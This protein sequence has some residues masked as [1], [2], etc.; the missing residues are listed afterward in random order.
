[1]CVYVYNILFCFLLAPP[2][3][4]Q[5]GD[6]IGG[7]EKRQGNMSPNDCI[8]HCAA[9]RKKFPT[10]NGVTVD[11]NGGNKCYCEYKMKS[12]NTARQWKTCKLE[13]RKLRLFVTYLS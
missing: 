9:L 12:R 7:T 13:F 2:C 1:M 10:I 11:A 3:T 6:G 8:A 4:F 5:R